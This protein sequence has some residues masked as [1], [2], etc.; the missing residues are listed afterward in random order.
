VSVGTPAGVEPIAELSVPGVVAFT[1]TR[2]RG[3]FNLLGEEPA[4]HV[5]DRWLKLQ[6]DLGVPRFA[7]AKQIHGRRVVTHN[8]GWTGWLRVDGADGHLAFAAG[9]ALA[10]TLADC[11]PVFL[12]HPGGMVGLL[13]AGWR[14]T[15]ARI[16]DQAAADLEA[17][18]HN[19]ADCGVHLGPA[20]CG[21]CYEVGPEVIRAIAGRNVAGPE[22]LDLRQALG[23]Q[24]AANGVRDISVSEYCTS[25][26]NARFFSH[27][28]GDAGRH[29]GV[30]ARIA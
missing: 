28:A 19:I 1:T 12:V 7:Y 11:V 8:D 26:H 27:R 29:I 14:G 9:T 18:G 20:I 21:K 15:A 6:E 30:I 24:L 17:H 3:D 4:V 22:R 16:V 10:V 23:E 5:V 13:H 2:E 25:C